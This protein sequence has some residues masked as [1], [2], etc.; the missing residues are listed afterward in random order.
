MIRTAATI[1]V[2][3][4]IGWIALRILFGFAG[5]VLGLLISLAVFVLKIALVVGLVYWLLTIFSP[6]TAK[7]MRDALR[8]ESL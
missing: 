5:G 7:K 4:L 2:V 8:G 1:A 6:E 3:A